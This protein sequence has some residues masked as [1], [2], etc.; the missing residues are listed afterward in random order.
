MDNHGTRVVTGGVHGVSVQQSSPD[1]GMVENQKH[2][3]Q[4]W[5]IAV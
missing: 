1:L 2:S 4:H 5:K 3:C